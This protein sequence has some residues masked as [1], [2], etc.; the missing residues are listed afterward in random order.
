MRKEQIMILTERLSDSNTDLLKERGTN[1]D[2]DSLIQ[3]EGSGSAHM[4]MQLKHKH[5][6]DVWKSQ[7]DEM[8]K[9]KKK[10]MT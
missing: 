7:K 6:I 9:L 8:Y 5:F 4:Q 10:V 3:G 2:Y 1:L